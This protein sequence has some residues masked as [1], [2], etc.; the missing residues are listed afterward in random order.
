MKRIMW[1][2]VVVAMLAAGIARGGVMDKQPGTVSAA[3]I[4]HHIQVNNGSGGLGAGGCTDDGSGNLSCNSIG[5]GTTLLLTPQGNA[6]GSPAN[7]MLWTTSL[8]LFAQI[9]GSTLGPL[10]TAPGALYDYSNTILTGY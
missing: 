1:L 4:V 10:G 7:G 6:P 8:G 9:N 2:V 5:S 3:G